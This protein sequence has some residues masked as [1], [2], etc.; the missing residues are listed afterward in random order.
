MKWIKASE[1]LPP[2]GVKVIIREDGKA[3]EDIAITGWDARITSYEWLD[4]SPAPASTVVV[5]KTKP[6]IVANVREITDLYDKEEISYSRMV[7]MLNEVAFRKRAYI[8]HIF[9]V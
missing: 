5:G 8:C 1:R 9:K 6:F 2:V 3:Y 7:E 4:E